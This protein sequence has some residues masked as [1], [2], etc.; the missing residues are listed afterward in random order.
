MAQPPPYV[1][2]TDFS[3]DELSNVG[4]RSTVRTAELDAE[5]A[6]LQ[7][8][9]AGLRTNLAAIQRD[10]T[11][12]RDGVVKLHTLASE[13][14]GLFA[15]GHGNVRGAWQ[16]G[17]SYALRDVVSQGGNSYICAIA[18]PAGTFST[19]LNA[20]R[21]VP[22]A[23]ASS[24]TASAVPFTP[25]GT[26]AATNVQAAIAEVAWD[27]EAPE[28]TLSA[29]N[30]VTIGAFNGRMVFITGTTTIENFGTAPVGVWKILRFNSTP[31]IRHHATWLIT[32]TGADLVATPY[33]R[34]LAFSLGSGNWRIVELQGGAFLPAGTGAQPQSLRARLAQ[35]V[36]ARDFGATGNGTTD[37]TAALQAFLTHCASNNLVGVLPE[38]TYR[39]TSTLAIASGDRWG[40]K[41]AHPYRSVLWYDGAAANVD[42]LRIGDGTANP[43]NL[44]LEGFTVR[45]NR[46]MTAG[47]GLHLRR[48]CRSFIRGVII[49]G[50]DG[51]GRLWHG[52]RF[53][54]V[55]SVFFDDFQIRAQKDGIQINGLA[56]GLP[57]ADLHLSNFKIASCDVGIRV[58]GAFGGLYFG[59][60]SV[61]VCGDSFVLDT[62]LVAEANREVFFDPSLVLDACSRSNVVIDQAI[63]SQLYVNFP[64][65]M[66]LA[67]AGSHCVWIKNAAGA[68]IKFNPYVYNVTG[69]GLRV[70]D[71]S[72]VVL[73]DDAVFNN[74]SGFGINVTVAS[75]NVKLSSPRFQGTPNTFNYAANRAV[76]SFAYPV[77]VQTGR[78]VYWES[79]NGT[80]DGAGGASVAHGKGGTWYTQAIAVFAAY[81]SAGGAWLPLTTN[82]IDGSNISLSGG[83][84][85][86]PYNVMVLVGDQANSGW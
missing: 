72:T 19:D 47:I 54:G 13:V 1:P 61:A 43:T 48:V 28:V 75:T 18:H 81:K 50:Q 21:W 66:W 4:G 39:F 20:G 59:P 84:A 36:S 22:L 30:L 77:Q 58:G 10:D 74:V 12:V 16:T 69:D 45:S 79:F 73:I 7:A 56:G 67:S 65:G 85:G 23:F 9:L 86:R 2:Q 80:L 33:N 5:F 62:T 26:V 35:T 38:G 51:N 70:D 76:T 78:A 60:G 82:F 44:L 11:E 64:D 40:I 31:I 53:N 32:D 37:D 68:K 6:N 83:G 71:A 57:K 27:L 14:L 17:Q 15:A 29:S 55:D 49:D 25:T 41:G 34:Y 3:D 63:S 46:T 52:L 42:L 8:T 24:V